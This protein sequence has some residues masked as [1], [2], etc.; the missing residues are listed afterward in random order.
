MSAGLFACPVDSDP[1]WPTIMAWIMSS[2]SPPRHSPTMMRSGRM[3]SALRSR[4]RVVI[5]PSPSRFG[6]RASRVM[7]WFW[8][9]CSSAASSIVMTR[10]LSGMNDDRTL[11]V[12][13]LPDPVPPDTNTLR[14]AS[15]QALRNSNIS[16]VAVPKLTRS[17]TVNGLAAN[18]RT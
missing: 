12:V 13:V 16:A 6:G 18:F 10:S 5:S 4:S 15:T 7:T 14:R 11:R 17:S 9:S 2:A 8:R 1:S 3:C